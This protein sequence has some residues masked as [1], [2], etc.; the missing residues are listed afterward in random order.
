MTIKSAHERAMMKISQ[1]YDPYCTIPVRPVRMR[2]KRESEQKEDMEITIVPSTTIYLR[3]DAFL[4]EKHLDR[5]AITYS[6]T[7]TRIPFP[8]GHIYKGSGHVC[9]GDIF[10][11]S[12]ISRY[13]PQQPLE[14]LFLHNDRNL[15]HGNASLFISAVTASKIQRILE[16]YRISISKDA[17][18]IFISDQNLLKHDEIWLLGA[19]VYRNMN[20]VEKA[21]K[22]M[23]RIYNLVFEE[24]GTNG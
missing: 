8:Y 24:R 12:K 13:C 10:V 18:G 17:S 6:V 5:N 20:D 15:S 9:L 7:G 19:D 3:P 16:E 23:T 2:V 14:T 4:D 22:I 11:P 1:K 21:V